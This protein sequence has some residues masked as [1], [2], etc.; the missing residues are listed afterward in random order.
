MPLIIQAS[1]VVKHGLHRGTLG[2]HPNEL[3]Y[4]II[5]STVGPLVSTLEDRLVE[6][7]QQ[8]GF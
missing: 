7:L 1:N 8:Q 4:S 3:Y 5:K 2:G 6:P